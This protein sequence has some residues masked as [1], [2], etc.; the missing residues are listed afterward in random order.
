MLE[1]RDLLEQQI[2]HLGTIAVRDDNPI[3]FGKSCNLS[4]WYLQI[5]ELFFDGT[6]LPFLDEGVS[7]QSDQ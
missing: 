7:A 6:D 3:V 4:H 1:K 2:P 5:L